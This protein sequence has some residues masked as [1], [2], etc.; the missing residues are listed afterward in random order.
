M[1]VH[2][3]ADTHTHTHTSRSKLRGLLNAQDRMVTIGHPE[4]R[5][6]NLENQKRT[7]P[8]ATMLFKYQ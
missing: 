3:H 6:L 1:C 7:P 8:T 5:S 4:L 2:T